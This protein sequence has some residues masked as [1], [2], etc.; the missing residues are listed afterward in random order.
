MSFLFCYF[1]PMYANVQT[2]FN[3]ATANKVPYYELKDL[4][5][6]MVVHIR[7]ALNLG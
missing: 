5:R 1:A 2:R 6:N 4:Y 3:L 7:I